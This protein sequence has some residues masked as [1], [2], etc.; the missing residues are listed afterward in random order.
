MYSTLAT[1][2]DTEDLPIAAAPPPLKVDFLLLPPLRIGGIL[3]LWRLT[4]ILS[5]AAASRIASVASS[6][7]SEE[8]SSVRARFSAGFRFPFISLVPVV[9]LG[10]L[11][12]LQYWCFSPN[13]LEARF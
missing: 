2:T 5:A 3:F 13:D 7:A 1:H 6:L 9:G 8:P 4:S 11:G 12:R 10:S